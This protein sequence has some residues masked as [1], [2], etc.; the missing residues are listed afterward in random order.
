MPTRSERLYYPP[1][2]RFRDE[3]MKKAPASGF[4]PDTGAS[5]LQVNRGGEYL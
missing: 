5:P 1:W 3:I 2:Q 4:P